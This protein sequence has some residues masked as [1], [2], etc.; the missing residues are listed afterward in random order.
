MT[1]YRCPAS[2]SPTRY[3]LM[4]SKMERR[5]NGMQAPF[6]GGRM[7]VGNRL[8]FCDANQF[9]LVAHDGEKIFLYPMPIDPP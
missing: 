2:T 4:N 8:A 3:Q 5:P 7:P 9:L 1:K 6:D